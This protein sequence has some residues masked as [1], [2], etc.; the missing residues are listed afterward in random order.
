MMKISTAP[1]KVLEQTFEALSGNPLAATAFG[2]VKALESAAI[3]PSCVPGGIETVEQRLNQLRRM[4]RIAFEATL[5]QVGI[6]S[7]TDA[8]F[9]AVQH[10][11][12]IINDDLQKLR[13]T[14]GQ[15]TE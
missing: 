9:S 1:D 2:I 13:K 3:D 8:Q 4:G 11:L 14:V 12:T 15:R 6:T 5:S 7:L 10:R